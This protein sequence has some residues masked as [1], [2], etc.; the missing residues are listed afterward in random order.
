[1]NQN[2]L[3]EI[4]QA[5]TDGAGEDITGDGDIT[6]DDEIMRRNIVRI[7]NYMNGSHGSQQNQTPQSHN[8][9]SSHSSHGSQSI[10]CPGL[11]HRKHSAWVP[12]GYQSQDRTVCSTCR[13]A[14]DIDAVK[15]T[16]SDACS[17][18]GFL[19][20]NNVTNGIVTL[21]C[22]KPG[23]KTQY[24]ILSGSIIHGDGIFHMLITC[25]LR[26]H[27]YYKYKLINGDGSI[28][29]ESAK[30]IYHTGGTL[31]PFPIVAAKESK[32]IGSS[33]KLED[34]D[35]QVK[36][37]GDITV[38]ITVYNKTQMNLQN[39]C[40]VYFGG[41]YVDKTSYL[42]D[43]RCALNKTINK[44]EHNYTLPGK[45]PNRTIPIA[46]ELVQFNKSPI[47]LTLSV[48]PSS[49]ESISRIESNISRSISAIR[50]RDQ[51]ALKESRAHECRQLR[52]KLEDLEEL[53]ELEALE[54]SFV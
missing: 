28:L 2:Q 35:E 33:M 44:I 20:N 12:V 31:V 23:F 6:G 8:S 48:S 15:Y 46:F 22:W 7:V 50:K 16:G 54:E 18:E 37:V 30:Y 41:Y 51:D 38:H 24:P 32:F 5:I 4:I 17:C 40:G 3:F 39:A 21:S 45:N 27:Q 36:I 47:V 14:Y 43:S 19:Y 11:T 1:M 49:Q 9:H 10:G 53:E 42:L 25:E 26:A 52:Q 29:Y 34:T 13:A